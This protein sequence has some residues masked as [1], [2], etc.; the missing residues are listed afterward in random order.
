MI[1]YV[2]TQG[3]KVVREGRH[4]LVRKEGDIHH[5]LFIHRLEQLVLMGN[6]SVTPQAM[7]LLL[8]EG[9]D[10]VFLRLDGRYQGRF[11][12]AE[13]KNIF[14]RKRQF[15][16][17]DDR[18]FCL[19]MAGRIVRGKLLNQAT[20]LQRIQRT[21]NIL[22][23]GDPAHAIRNLCHKLEEATSVETVRG[24]EG[25]GASLYFCGFPRGFTEDFGFR[26]RVRRPPT[27][28]VN[29]VL[30]LLY[31]FI[32]NRAY[33]AVR[34]AGLDPYPGALHSLDYGRFSL[35][36]DLV[37]EFRT[38][39]VDTLTLSLF[40]LGI[41]KQDDFYALVPPPEVVHEPGEDLIEQ[42][43]SDRIGS[44]SL[45]DGDEIFDMPE[46][47][48]EEDYRM[49]EER[50]AMPAVRLHTDA[51]ARV[52]KAFER[53]MGTEFYHPLAEKKLTYS[54]SL[55]FQARLYRKVVEGEAA[56]YHPLLLK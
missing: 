30:S 47:K 45:Q 41:L 42:A 17:T 39:I 56:D 54:E 3:A 43:L 5:T 14:L 37:E 55:I 1:V 9:I 46:Q 52:I 36:L 25:A 35:P 38:I 32:I 48:V 10:T 7:K 26:R 28:P 16:L 44:M 34:L 12:S 4:L 15:L 24:L 27:D 18:D 23:P 6:V 40:N 11:A 2:S 22:L 50:S 33:A 20:L 13:P 49:E 51:L 19:K 21:R 8:R 53:K 31:T 29:A